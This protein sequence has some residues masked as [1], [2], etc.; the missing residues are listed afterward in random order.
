MRENNKIMRDLNRRMMKCDI[1]FYIAR[2][3]RI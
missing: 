1:Y 2:L 3:G